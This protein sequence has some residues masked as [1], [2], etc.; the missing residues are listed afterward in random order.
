MASFS[1]SLSEWAARSREENAEGKER[2]LVMAIHV[3]RC[4][5]SV[6]IAFILGVTSVA[7]IAQDQGSASQ[8]EAVEVR[9]TYSAPAGLTGDEIV[10]KMIERNRLR[11]EQLRRYSAV[12]TY[13]IRN[14]EGKLAAQAV[15]RVEYW[16]PDKKTFNKTS[17]KGSGIV[18]HLVFDRLMQSESETSSGREHHD[19]A[20]TTM[21]YTF[22]LSGEEDVG[23]YHCFVLEATAKRKEKYLF[24]GRIW[25][26][27]TDFAVAKIAGRPA[28]KPSFWINRADF[29]R[30]YQRIDGFWLPWRDETSVEVKMYGRRAFTVDHQ[31]YVIN[32]ANPLQAET[33]NTGGED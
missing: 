1:V 14:P 28:K 8:T 31:Q 3:G 27:T 30:Q 33:G 6:A 24:E 25:I 13:D 20:I 9:L 15:V 17:E 21:N 5:R 18:R 26:D 12:R 19:S 11:N 32:P 29:V 22:T 4:G 2:L 10:S 7:S 16:A 23:P